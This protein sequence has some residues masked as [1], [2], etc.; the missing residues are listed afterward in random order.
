MPLPMHRAHALLTA[1]LTASVLHAQ[2]EVKVS[3]YM[4]NGLFL[5]PAYAGSHPYASGSLLY[6]DQWTRM[7]G[8]PN[9]SMGAL[10]APLKNGRIGIGVSVVHDR[11]GISRD[12]DLSSHFAYRIRTG[13][14][15]YLAFGLRAGVAFC[16][17]RFD[18]LVTWDPQDP[19]YDRALVNVPVLRTGAGIFWNDGRSYAGLSAP[20][21]WSADRRMRVAPGGRTERYF[22]THWYLTAGRAFPINESI[23]LK[24]S[25]LVRIA[26]SAAPQVDL[27]CNLLF[28][29]R[30]W[31]GVGYRTANGPVALVEYQVTPLLRAGYAYDMTT[32]RLGGSSGVSHEV[33]LGIDLG[34]DPVRIRSPRYF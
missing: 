5:N 10:D 8:A 19:A 13:G 31:L 30:V 32:S 27:T 20:D 18:E 3:Q 22:R 6:R 7:P 33:M 28:R 15:G 26:P 25:L 4:F 1:V 11:I 9:T 21:L 29:E 16:S 2:Q 17:A 34:R 12:L 23:D 24:P 14:K